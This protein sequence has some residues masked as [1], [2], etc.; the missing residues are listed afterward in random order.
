MGDVYA[1]VEDFTL[2]QQHYQKGGEIA[3]EIGDR[4]L[5]NYL[6][7]AQ[8]H[9]SLQQLDFD[10]TKRLLNDANRLIS[11][12]ASQYEEAL[13]KMLRGQFFLHQ[14]KSEQARDALE[15][16]E[17]LFKADGRNVEYARSQLLLAA[18]YYRK[19]SK[20]MLVTN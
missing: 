12:Q 6:S 11:S 4:F 8:A 16:S 3:R 5:L 10:K 1:E 13:Y 9:L 19:R 17:A 18:A 2:A 15:A 14:K 7:L 20:M